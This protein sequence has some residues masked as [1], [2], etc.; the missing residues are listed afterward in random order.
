MEVLV[1]FVAR[2]FSLN[3]LSKCLLLPVLW[4]KVRY[5]VD[6]LFWK[7]VFWVTLSESY[8]PSELCTL[9]MFLGYDLNANKEILLPNVVFRSDLQQT[10]ET[11]WYRRRRELSITYFFWLPVGSSTEEVLRADALGREVNLDLN[12]KHA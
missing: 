1:R 3:F 6:N 11:L 9:G 2:T 10:I 5:F 7:C 4:F 8:I 12:L